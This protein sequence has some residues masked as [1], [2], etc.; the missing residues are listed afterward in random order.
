MQEYR[1]KGS[2][3]QNEGFFQ[4]Q[5]GLKLKEETAKVLHL[6]HNLVWC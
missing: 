1:G 4:E 6:G 3:Q 5:I 2:I